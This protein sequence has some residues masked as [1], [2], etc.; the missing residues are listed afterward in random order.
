VGRS[1]KPL[2]ILVAQAW[3]THEKIQALAAQGHEIQVA[4]D[5]DLIL[6]PAAHW[7]QDDMWPFLP[8]ALK[9]ARKRNKETECA[10]S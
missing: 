5:A 10:P 3:L 6:S 7:W 9:A 1:S 2:T 4:P 8:V